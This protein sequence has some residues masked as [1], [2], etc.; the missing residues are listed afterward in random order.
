[1]EGRQPKAPAR[2]PVVPPTAGRLAAVAVAAAAAA[3]AV[4]RG[5]RARQDKR[6]KAQK[7]QRSRHRDG[8]R[9]RCCLR[10]LPAGEGRPAIRPVPARPARVSPRWMLSLSGRG[11]PAGRWPIGQSPA[12]DRRSNGC[13]RSKRPALECRSSAG[14]RR[15]EGRTT[16]VIRAG[17]LGRG[18]ELPVEKWVSRTRAAAGAS[19]WERA[20]SFE[21]RGRSRARWAVRVSWAG[22]WMRA[23]RVLSLLAGVCGRASWS[24]VGVGDRQATRPVS[25]DWPLPTSKASALWLGTLRP[26][27]PKR[28]SFPGQPADDDDVSLRRSH[29]LTRARP[30]GP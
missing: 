30:T 25:S 27:L 11:P 22:E 17:G 16:P 18:G 5:A 24:L 19:V 13:D 29:L 8:S 23:C 14:E 26:R 4:G 21:G 28:R 7:G 3:A 12:A 15:E 1:M 20:R 10:L 2:A 9:R 6:V